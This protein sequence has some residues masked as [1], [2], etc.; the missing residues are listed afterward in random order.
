MGNMGVL[1]VAFRRQRRGHSS[2][3]GAQQDRYISTLAQ[4]GR[5]SR[6]EAE[7][8]SSARVRCPLGG[9]AVVVGDQSTRSGL[10]TTLEN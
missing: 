8:R 9:V 7:F 1:L 2:R 4:I 3:P 6:S 10:S 5:I